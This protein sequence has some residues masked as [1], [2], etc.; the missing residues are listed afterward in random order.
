MN[1]EQTNPEHDSQDLP[2]LDPVDNPISM[3][4]VIELRNKG[5]TYK[6][7]GQIFGCSKQAIHQRLQPFIPSID[8]L[9]TSKHHRADTL[10]VIND[11]LLNSLTGDDIKKSSPYQRVGMFG[12][13]YD[14]ER[15]E[16]GEST[17]NVAYKD[18][19]QAMGALDK[20]IKA[21]EAELGADDE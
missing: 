18:Q 8:N 1:T 21:I 6:E 13:L 16:R 12:V 2:T 10:H 20:E 5:L 3:A 15:L 19:S 17:Q 9:K 4:K 11:T 7:I 14:K